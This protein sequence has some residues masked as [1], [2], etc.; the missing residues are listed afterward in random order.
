MF[1]WLFAYIRSLFAPRM[2]YSK[3]KTNIVKLVEFSSSVVVPSA[4]NVAGEITDL[5]GKEVTLISNNGLTQGMSQLSDKLR[6]KLKEKLKNRNV[7]FILDQRVTI[8]AEEHETAY[9]TETRKWQL[10]NGESIE[11]DLMFARLGHTE[12]NTALAGSLGDN[13][14]NPDTQEIRI[15]PTMQLIVHDNIFAVNNCNGSSRKMTL[16]ARLQTVVAV[17]KTSLNL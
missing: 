9:V 10:S 11:T 8:T 6:S 7:K 5:A 17:K 15:R 13:V 2:T 16:I 12:L 3:K 1:F 14:L 4:L